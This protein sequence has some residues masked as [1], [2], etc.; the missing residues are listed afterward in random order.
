MS[1]GS[2]VRAESESPS[3]TKQPI[4]DP[5]AKVEHRS[6]SF[7]DPLHT[8]VTDTLRHAGLKCAATYEMTVELVS[9]LANYQEE[10]RPIA[11]KV[12]ICNSADQLVQRLGG[13][14][15]VRIGSGEIDDNTARR[16]LKECAPL[17]EDGWF[18]FVE[19]RDEKAMY[20]VLSAGV[21]FTSVDPIEI[22]LSDDHGFPV[23]LIQ[24]ISKRC[25]EIRDNRGR[26]RWAHFTGQEQLPERSEDHVSTLATVISRPCEV[27]FRDSLET[28]MRRGLRHVIGRAHGAL[29]VITPAGKA[30]PELLKDAVVLAP[31]LDLGERLK[32]HI[33]QKQTAETL[34]SL[35]A[36]INLLAGM[37]TSDG[38]VVI[39]E[40]GKVLGYRGFIQAAAVQ[41]E[42]Q[43]GGARTRAFSAMEAAVGTHFKAAFFCS[44]DGNTRMVV[45]NNL[46]PSGDLA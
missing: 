46:A 42:H 18:I 41:G 16:A 20:G 38:I 40:G 1:A 22:A 32:R 44:Q 8:S 34:S 35:Q 14:E 27:E 5:R 12:F 3:P 28:L 23:V 17:A 29:I 39:E 6:I 7:R 21:D 36:G 2:D 19:R 15:L 30:F 9:Q 26:S 45:E 31:P 25:V 11:P 13:G 33:L 43:V 10:G 37:V 4:K 24:Q